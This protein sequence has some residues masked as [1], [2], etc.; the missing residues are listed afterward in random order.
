MDLDDI[1][2]MPSLKRKPSS[3][4]Q[5][6]RHNTSMDNLKKQ[7]QNRA[8]QILNEQLFNNIVSPNISVNP[9]GSG[10]NYRGSQLLP[11]KPSKYIQPELNQK[12]NNLQ[13]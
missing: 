1:Y 7:N 2:M 12:R 13:E 6:K 10:N 3:A 11:P 4:D 9:E 8:N 5:Q